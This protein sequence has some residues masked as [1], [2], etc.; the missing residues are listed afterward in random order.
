MVLAGE[1]KIMLRE[2][3]MKDTDNIIRWRNN[4]NVR[5]KFCFQETF[6]NEMHMN[7]YNTRVKTGNVVQFIIVDQENNMDIGS[8]YLRDIDLKNR[9][10]E[11]GIFIG[12]NIARGKGS[13]TKATKRIIEYGF[14]ELKLNKIFLRVFA[15]NLRAIA[16]YKKAGFEEEGIFK[17]DV[18]VNAGE[19]KDMVF[20]AIFNKN[21][22]E[23]GGR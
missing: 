1:G 5:S 16:S 13:G 15:D 4:P 2:I 23:K 10:A 11:F 21:C 14:K 19:Y 18:I 3:D 12:E 17:Q 7:W 22:I 9:K 8:V 20:M 6:T